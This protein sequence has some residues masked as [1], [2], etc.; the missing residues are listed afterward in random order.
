MTVSTGDQEG[1]FF[2]TVAIDESFK[3]K[4]AQ[5]RLVVV[6]LDNPHVHGLISEANGQMQTEKLY[7]ENGSPF[8]HVPLT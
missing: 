3:F 2:T 6:V 4:L 5:L 7:K 8:C 1:V